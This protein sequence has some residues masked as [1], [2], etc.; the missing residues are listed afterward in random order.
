MAFAAGLRELPAVH[1]VGLVA[2]D[3][4]GGSLA[5]CLSLFV[6]CV[7]FERGMGAVEREVGES[8][9]ELSPAQL[10]DVS[11]ASLVL[12][13]ARAALPGAGVG[14]EAVI[15]LVQPHVGGD[16]LVAIEAQRGL[17]SRI[18]TVVAVGA[19]LLLL[20]MRLRQFAGHQQRLYVG[21]ACR[22]ERACE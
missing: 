14:H 6:T 7:T 3:A 18:G 9:V 2:A 15:T 22:A 4:A 21:C 8:V 17:R 12:R 1:I 11:L 19:V 5:P 20:D 10:N 13:M 16:I